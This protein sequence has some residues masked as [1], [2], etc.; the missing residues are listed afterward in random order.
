[1]RSSATSLRRLQAI[2]GGLAVSSISLLPTPHIHHARAAE[3]GSAQPVIHRHVIDQ[4]GTSTGVSS[5]EDHRTA[6]FLDTVF[7]PEASSA[8]LDEVPLP[9]VRYRLT[10]P[11][12]SCDEDFI[13]VGEVTRGSPG[14]TAASRAPPRSLL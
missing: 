5:G 1:M 10:P 6:A 2:F 13:A 3:G 7:R 4:I 11:A 8:S 12:D 14:R 9:A